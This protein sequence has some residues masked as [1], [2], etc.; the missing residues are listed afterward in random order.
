MTDLIDAKDV[1]RML[2]VSL[3]LVYKLAEQKRLPCVRIPCLGE[4]TTK[5]RTLVRFK[6]QDVIDFIER[7]YH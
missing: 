7:H 4:G 3:P 5:P 2:K 6:M 1:R